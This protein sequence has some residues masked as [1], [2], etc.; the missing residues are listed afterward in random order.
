MISYN[1]PLYGLTATH[2]SIYGGQ[3]NMITAPRC[4]PKDVHS[5]LARVGRI[6]LL[7]SRLIGCGEAP[8]PNDTRSG[9]A[10]GPTKSRNCAVG[11]VASFT[12][13]RRSPFLYPASPPSGG[14][15]LP[16]RRASGYP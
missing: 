5:L 7:D 14:W 12:C 4:E 15:I 9:D 16:T 6:R 2:K 11:A 8:R 10:P 1:I 13:A 3:R